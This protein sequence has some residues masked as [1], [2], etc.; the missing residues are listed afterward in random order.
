MSTDG[1][2]RQISY[3]RAAESL[4]VHWPAAGNQLL[5]MSSPYPEFQDMSSPGLVT[6]EKVQRPL[7]SE[8]KRPDKSSLT[9]RR[10][11]HLSVCS[12]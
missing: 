11:P 1:I 4:Y 5:W 3:D 2:G 9:K 6:F 12:S 10:L 7:I 8:N